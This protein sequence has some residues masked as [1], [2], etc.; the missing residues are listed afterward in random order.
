MLVRSDKG[1]EGPQTHTL[2]LDAILDALDRL[3]QVGAQ[4][5]AQVL[6]K[7]N[8]DRLLIREV[9]VKGALPNIRRFG[10]VRDRGDLV[11]L[12][13]K[14]QLR[15]LQDLLPSLLAARCGRKL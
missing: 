12:L 2:H 6:D 9:Q 14:D 5:L 10:D 15:G 4:H 8:N 13:P 1:A 7:L 11:A 3:G